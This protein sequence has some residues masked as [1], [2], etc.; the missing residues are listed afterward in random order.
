MDKTLNVFVVDRHAIAIPGATVTFSYNGEAISQAI[1]V[2]KRSRPVR[3]QFSPAYEVITVRVDYK[4]YSQKAT[5][6]LNS[7]NYEFVFEEVAMPRTNV[8]LAVVGVLIVLSVIAVI[9]FGM[10]SITGAQ[11]APWIFGAVFIGFFMALIWF[12]PQ[13][14]FGGPQARILRVLAAVFVGL[15][16]A[17]FSGSL[18]L[19]GKVPF[20]SDLAVEATGGFA[21]FFLVYSTWGKPKEGE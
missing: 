20:F 14:Q 8:A 17:F 9:G 15:I 2:G 3:V 6:D 1:T 4:K 11:Q 10:R 18:H 13:E 12:K 16:A 21:G 7:G 19:G 5:V